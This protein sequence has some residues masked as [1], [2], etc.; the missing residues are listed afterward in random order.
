MNLRQFSLVLL[1][2]TAVSGG[3]AASPPAEQ[4]GSAPKQWHVLDWG[5]K[6]VAIGSLDPGS[7]YTFRVELS[8]R[9]G[10][11]NTIKL[12]KYYTT[13][14]DKQLAAK[15][16]DDHQAYLA[17]VRKNPDK[18]KGHYSLLNP[19]GAEA[20]N[21]P[22]ATKSLTV[23]DEEG[24]KL[25]WGD[26]SQHNWEMQAEN[27]QTIRMTWTL[28]RDAETGKAADR[29]PFL[30]VH[31]TYT[32]SKNSYT[33]DVSIRLE[34]LSS[35]RLKVEL[36]QAGP[37]GLPRED[38]RTDMREAAYGKLEGDSQRV[39]PYLKPPKELPKIQ[40]GGRHVVGYSDSRRDDKGATLWIGH[41]N[42]FFGSMMYLVPEAP[43]D[44]DR[45][46]APLYGASFYVSAEQE[47]HDSRTF[48]T[49]IQVPAVHLA[50]GESKPILLKLFAGPKKR[51]IFADENAPYFEPLYK[52][53][54]YLSTISLKGCFCAWSW[55]SLSLMWLLQQFSKA[56]WGNYGVAIILLV[57]LVRVVLHPLTK[58]SQVSMM[59]MQ[60][61]GPQMQKLK[62]KYADDKE[63]LNRE[64]MK[65][66]KQQGTTPL[67]GC[68]PMLLQMPIWIA[69]FTA[70]RALVELR[71]AAFLP[72]WLT[73]LAAPDIVFSWTTPLPLIGT[74]LH[75]LP[76]LL[77]VAMFL[78]T[79]LNPQMAGQAA[80]ASPDQAKQQ[81]MMKYMMPIMMLFI[82]YDMPSGLNLYIMTSTSAG[83]AEQF[84]IRRHIR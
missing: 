32:V 10:A 59:K 39:Q 13:V 41:V 53:L 55:L 11:I 23:Y 50:P 57:I 76:I 14:E 27:D 78:Q 22:L 77:T 38:R 18:Y 81:K 16:K 70:L 3:Y 46:D 35:Q 61:L 71:H 67:L 15:H 84:V 25:W 19:V 54:N 63:A 49:G 40:L 17:E 51:D 79:K 47:S 6:K 64:M 7:G 37:S 8:R 83:V 52:K 69:L 34:N 30:A 28:Y 9:A 60:K 42:K 68:L 4:Q 48:L 74:N 62:E 5:S 80:T 66:Y 65:F 36:D 58:K 29:K 73:D 44:N 82:F 31:K 20:A 45:L 12:S 2:F 43:Q 33:I 26:L 56:A 24:G 21:L 1:V 75:L 72:F